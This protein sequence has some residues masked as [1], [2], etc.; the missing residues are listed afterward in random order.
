[1]EEIVKPQLNPKFKGKYSCYSSIRV[2]YFEGNKFWTS[3]GL[4]LSKETD[5]LQLQWI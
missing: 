5:N 2:L 1:M 4:W 3:K